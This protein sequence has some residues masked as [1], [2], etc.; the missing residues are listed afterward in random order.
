MCGFPSVFWAGDAFTS[1]EGSCR[2]IIE[3]LS[4]LSLIAEYLLAEV[5][6]DSAPTKTDQGPSVK[7]VPG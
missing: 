7:E 2:A 4:H 1:D 5:S 3:T 6:E